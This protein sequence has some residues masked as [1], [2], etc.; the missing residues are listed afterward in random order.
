MIGRRARRLAGI[1]PVLWLFG[2]CGSTPP[3]AAPANP[4]RARLEAALAALPTDAPLSLRYN[5]A[6]CDCPA[7]EMPLDGAWL[8]VEL[9][10]SG[11]VPELPRLLDWLAAQPPERWPI[12]LS[13]R[14]ALERELL[15]T[16]SGTYAARLDVTAVLGPAEAIAP[17]AAPAPAV[18][19]TGQPTAP[20]SP[21]PTNP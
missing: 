7:F 20:E 14:G 2:A 8:R 21:D 18:E 3:V 15:R 12:G 4:L 10:A 11:N 13:L 9:V 5:P 19:P 16:S 17:A 1:A 6:P